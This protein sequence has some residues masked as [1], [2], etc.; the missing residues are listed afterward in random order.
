M[1]MIAS[2]AASCGCTTLKFIYASRSI[3]RPIPQFRRPTFPA[4]QLLNPV[5]EGILQAD[6]VRFKDYAAA[7]LANTKAA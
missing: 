6:M 3:S 1:T 4:A 5:V 2:L 7:H